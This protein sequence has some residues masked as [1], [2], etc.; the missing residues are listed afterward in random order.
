MPDKYQSYMRS[1]IRST[2]ETKGRNPDIAEAMVDERKIVEGIS[3]EG[4][5]L[6]LTSKEAVQYKIANGVVKN[7]DE[8]LEKLGIETP[9][10][11]KH[12]LTTI[13]KVVNF[14]LN[15]VVNSILLMI[16]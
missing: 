16:I 10:V 12:Q 9:E 14:L 3:E 13:D 4:K 6:T 5:V 8:V 2:A 1:M 7:L 11:Q 15:P